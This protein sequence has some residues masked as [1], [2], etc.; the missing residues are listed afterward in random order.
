MQ[1]REQSLLRSLALE[2]DWKLYKVSYFCGYFSV[3]VLFLFFFRFLDEAYFN[4][5]WLKTEVT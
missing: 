1:T 3:S 4:L 2:Q 5:C